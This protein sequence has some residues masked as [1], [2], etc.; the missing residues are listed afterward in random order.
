LKGRGC[1][2]CKSPYPGPSRL[3]RSLPAALRCTARRARRRSSGYP[4]RQRGLGVRQPILWRAT[5]VTNQ[6]RAACVPI[7]G[8][9][10]RHRASSDIREHPAESIGGSALAAR[11]PRR[12]VR[13]PAPDDGF[14]LSGSPHDL[15]GAVVVGSQKDDFRPPD[16]L[17][18][19]VTIGDDRLQLSAVSPAQF[20]PGSFVHSPDSHDRVH[21]GIRKRIEL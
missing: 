10:N 21:R 5:T 1:R 6:L 2:S 14:G 11:P 7:Y 20:N 19:A 8:C 18:R 4:R 12:G 9:G 13:E 15:D 3:A 17:L 16:M